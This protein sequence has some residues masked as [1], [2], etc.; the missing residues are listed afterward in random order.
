MTRIEFFI[1]RLILS[2]ASVATNCSSSLEALKNISHPWETVEQC[3]KN[4]VN[5]R[6]PLLETGDLQIDDYL[7]QFPAFKV[8]KAYSLV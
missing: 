3:W 7:S 1:D 2:S 4:S 8:D 6:L 5:V